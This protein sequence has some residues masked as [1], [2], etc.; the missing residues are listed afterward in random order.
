[1]YVCMFCVRSKE[2]SQK[3]LPPST[4]EG[5]VNRAPMN[6]T[7]IIFQFIFQQGFVSIE[8]H[9]MAFDLDVVQL[10][11]DGDRV[12]SAWAA[13]NGLSSRTFLCYCLSRDINKLGRTALRLSKY[14]RRGFTFLYPHQFPMAQF[15]ELESVSCNNPSF[16]DHSSINFQ[17]GQN[18]DSFD[19]QK[20]LFG[21]S[22]IDPSLEKFEYQLKYNLIK[23]LP[24][25]L[26][27]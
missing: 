21:F 16:I 6:V 12:L 4:V 9:L 26:M 1:M 14:I 19:I 15:L 25:Y 23:I 18:N 10:C 22:L 20:H 5:E 17:F 3:I 2:S 24:T 7:C 13:I 11:H 27:S 8:N